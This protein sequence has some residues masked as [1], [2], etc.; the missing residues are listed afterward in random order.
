MMNYSY[1]YDNATVLTDMSLNSTH[2][3]LSDDAYNLTNDDDFIVQHIDYYGNPLTITGCYFEECDFYCCDYTYNNVTDIYDKDCSIEIDHFNRK[4]T[5]YDI[6][7]YSKPL[8][9][10]RYDYFEEGNRSICDYTYNNVTDIYDKVCSIDVDYANDYANEQHNY[11]NGYDDYLVQSSNDHVANYRYNYENGYSKPLAIIRSSSAIVSVVSSLTLIWMV[12]RSPQRLSTTYHRLILGMAIGDILFSLSLASYNAMIPNEGRNPVWNAHGNQATCNV[13]GFMLVVGIMMSSLYICSLNFY[14]L[15][16]V[17]HNRT[18]SYIRTKMEP[19]LHGVPIVM[20]LA[21]GFAM[22][23]TG[24]YDPSVDAAT[25]SGT[26]INSGEIATSYITFVLGQI[27]VTLVSPITVGVT[28]GR[29]HRHVSRQERRMGRYGEGAFNPNTPQ[30]N[31]NATADSSVDESNGITRMMRMIVSCVTTT[32]R[33][34][35][36]CSNSNR[37]NSTSHVVMIR[38]RA[39]TIAY[40]LTWGW[41]FVQIA[42]E[43]AGSELAYGKDGKDWTT[44]TPGIFVYLIAIFIPLQGLWNLLIFMYPKVMKAKRARG[45]NLSWCEAIIEAFCPAINRWRERRT[46]DIGEREKPQEEEENPE[47]E[48]NQQQPGDVELVTGSLSLD[49]RPGSEEEKTEIEA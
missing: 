40:F 18:D 34:L 48:D 16:I 12:L 30:E 37:N 21:F 27:I 17:K 46:R 42:L 23:A 15:A 6:D 9:F 19:F 44:P 3:I 47:I 10:P 39:Y 36:P 29:M 22:L 20:S 5:Y 35:S 4:Y 43:N 14:S 7:C 26:C 49:V 38:A 1:D 32:F 28:L 33:R 11:E 31:N 41:S 25:N 24:G 8:T 45:G 13:S 2:G